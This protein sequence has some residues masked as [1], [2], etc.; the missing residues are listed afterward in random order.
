MPVRFSGV[1]IL[2][3]P[4]PRE[5]NIFQKAAKIFPGASLTE[6]PNDTVALNTGNPD[7]QD[8]DSFI[9]LALVDP[10]DTFPYQILPAQNMRVFQYGTMQYKNQMEADFLRFAEDKST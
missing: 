6:L 5:L 2:Y 10:E 1:H 9:T 4:T 7:F 8:A 3:R